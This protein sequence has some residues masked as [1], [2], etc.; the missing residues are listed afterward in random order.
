MTYDEF[1]EVVYNQ[2]VEWQKAEGWYFSMRLR[3]SK[4]AETDRF[5]GT[6]NYSYFGT[7][8]WKIKSGYPG[9]ANDPIDVWFVKKQDGLEYKIEL[10]QTRQPDD[11]QNELVLELNDSLS[12]SDG[13]LW[14][15]AKTNSSERK[16]ASTVI[17]GREK[18]YT[19]TDELLLDLYADLQLFIPRVDAVIKQIKSKNSDFE[20][21]RLGPEDTKKFE[22]SYTLRQSKFS[23]ERPGLESAPGALTTAQWEKFLNDKGVFHS[24]DLSIINAFYHS[25]GYQNTTWAVDGM[26]RGVAADDSQTIRVNGAVSRLAQRIEQSLNA[27][28][29]YIIRKDGTTCYWSML[30]NGEQKG[31]YYEWEMVPNLVTAYESYG[32]A[33]SPP[34]PVLKN[35]VS[36]PSHPLNQ[37]L[38]GPPGTGKTYATIEMAVRIAN[39]DFTGFGDRQ[40]LH[41]EFRRLK[42]VRRIA[43][44]TFHQSLSYEDFVEGLKPIINKDPEEEAGEIKYEIKR[45]IFRDATTTAIYS[46]VEVS[47]AEEEKTALNFAE[48]YDAFVK[49]AQVSLAEEE[50]VELKTWKGKKVYVRE[51]S[52]KKSM[53]IYHGKDGETKHTV[54]RQRLIKLNNKIKEK[55]EIS[56]IN[57]FIP[58][59]IG[60]A[61][62]S[63]YFA[64]WKAV[65][66][67]VPPVET[68]QKEEDSS[69]DEKADIISE[70]DLNELDFDAVPAHVLI[71][72][73]INRGNV[74]AILGELITLLEPDKR[75]G[76]KEELK[77]TLPYSREEFGVPPNLYIIGTMNTADRS[78][79]ALDA[80]LRRRFTFREVGP[81]PEVIARAHP[82][83]GRI[84]V[85]E[86]EVYMAELLAMINR[87]I[88]AL[89]DADHLLGH[90]YFL[91]VNDWK[92][93]ASAFND[94]IIPLLREYF[95]AHY[96]QMQLVVGKGFCAV[97]PTE[98]TDFAT[99]D[100][101][102]DDYAGEYKSY[103]FPAPETEVELEA[104]LRQLGLS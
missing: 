17:K 66:D 33:A 61:N 98:T 72:D 49:M 93:L 80:A 6:R 81:D 89:K 56:N 103:R 71:I 79:E 92:D 20:A 48:K 36:M 102:V 42:E 13:A 32:P 22:K 29:E 12:E 77:V 74:S 31:K 75:L 24:Y 4:G 88:K 18:R 28:F 62:Y 39:P 73:E 51:L 94:R 76:A 16:I 26:I 58:E 27:P 43:F 14:E 54:S 45:G 41:Q 25:P 100:D 50:P 52:E 47:E 3:P 70:L 7:T 104:A 78:V 91:R 63:A 1:E 19:S 84:K 67:F 10:K 97:E 40:A 30:F 96:G 34:T 69:I 64:A 21:D 86:L 5:I 101:E 15:R 53:W 35:H 82:T 60:G 9:S 87:R 23:T 37:I 83:S 38:Y 46:A 95:F 11:R 2:L 68:A 44:T 85:G 65:Q 57:K 8:F 90:S 59:A 55:G 99:A